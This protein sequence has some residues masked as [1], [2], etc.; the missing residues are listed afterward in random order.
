MEEN[1]EREVI[2]NLLSVELVE[3]VRER[4]PSGMS[5][6]AQSGRGG[7]GCLDV[8][9][10]EVYVR[11]DE[12]E[13]A[14]DWRKETQNEL[15][16]PKAVGRLT[17]IEAVSSAGVRDPLPAPPAELEYVL[18]ELELVDKRRSPATPRIGVAAVDVPQGEPTED[19]GPLAPPLDPLLP[20]PLCPFLDPERLECPLPGASGGVGTSTG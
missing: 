20:C 1:E 18:V 19:L 13:E 17:A 7:R 15:G 8:V 12:E 4:L 3:V 10:V 16:F 5:P 6:T 11:R 14:D 2:L 9:D